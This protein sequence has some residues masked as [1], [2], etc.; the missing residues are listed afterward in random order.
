MTQRLMYDGRY[1]TP[2]SQTFCIHNAGKVTG[3]RKSFPLP[4]SDTKSRFPQHSVSS[5]AISA[6]QSV[7]P[8][9]ST[10][11]STCMNAVD[12]PDLDP[13]WLKIEPMAV[14]HSTFRTNLTVLLFE[15]EGPSSPGRGKVAPTH[16]I[17]FQ[18]Y[19]GALELENTEAVH[20]AH[21]THTVWARP[22][23][24]RRWRIRCGPFLFSLYVEALLC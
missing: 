21:H 13:R 23:P 4:G 9:V 18:Y 22:F 14:R 16:H 24:L 8:K 17:R 6:P 3:P 20:F 11:L 2:V 19:R 10:P 1:A 15:L 12:C 5:P 7:C